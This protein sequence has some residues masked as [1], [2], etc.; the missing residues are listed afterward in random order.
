LLDAD[1][2][3]GEIDV[4][5]AQR[6]QFALPETGPE[7]AEEQRVPVNKS[8]IPRYALSDARHGIFGPNFTFTR[9][10]EP[11]TIILTGIELVSLLRKRRRSPRDDRTE[12]I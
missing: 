9:V 1:E 5:P 10:P 12:Q 11:S 4:G 7:R 3:A 8:S 6:Q 2:P